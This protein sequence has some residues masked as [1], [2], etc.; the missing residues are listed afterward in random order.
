[1]ERNLISWQ[2]CKNPND[3]N[4]AIRTKDENWDRLT[5]A[6]QIISITYDTNHGC[7]VVFWRYSEEV[8]E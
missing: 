8:V 4:E 6:R 7:Y 1:M 2:Y 3:I 5:D